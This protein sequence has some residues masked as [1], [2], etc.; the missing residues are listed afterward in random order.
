MTSMTEKTAPPFEQLRLGISSCLLGQ[1]VR[2]DGGHK[3]DRFLT[4][5]LGDYVTWVPV[6]PEVEIGL[7]TPRPTIRLERMEDGSARLVMPSSGEDLTDRMVEYADD[8]IGRLEKH[9]LAGY[10]LKKDSPS[11]GM[12]RVKVRDSNGMPSRTGVGTFAAELLRLAPD[13]PVEE[14]GRLN[15]ARLR[16]NFI[17]RIFAYRRWRDLEQSGPTRRRLMEFHAAH[18]YVLM[19]RNQ[20]GMRRLGR[21]LGDSGR[22]DSARALAAAYRTGLTEVMRRPPGRKGHTNVLRHLAGYVSDGLDS[23]DRSE[24]TESIGQYHEGLVPLIVPVTLLRH[25]V[26]KFDVETLQNQVYLWPHPH[27]LMLLNHV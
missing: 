23:G 19:S 4:D 3:R 25:Y 16:E 8:R 22:R 11:C 6:C 27:E 21:L 1:E 5:V 14:E 2:Y 10:V 9:D 24:L 13:L 15:D 26:R 20:A 7:G 18:K 17:T 12:E